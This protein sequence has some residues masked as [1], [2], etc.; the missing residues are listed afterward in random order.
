VPLTTR[1]RDT[2]DRL[3]RALWAQ[4]PAFV[5][6]FELICSLSPALPSGS[7]R[8]RLWRRF[9]A[10]ARPVAMTVAVAV[11]VVRAVVVV[12]FTSGGATRGGC[13]RAGGLG[14]GM[15]TLGKA[16]SARDVCAAQ[17]PASSR[18]ASHST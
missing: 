14:V 10:V 12:A 7:R 3:E 16:A 15:M 8:V 17:R 2:I 5:R 1:E 4:D 11:A 6:R 9:P 13:G 18:G